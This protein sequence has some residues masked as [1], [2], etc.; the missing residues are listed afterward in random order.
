MEER[1]EQIGNVPQVLEERELI[2]EE[3]KEDSRSLSP[4]VELGI[5]LWMTGAV[6]KEEA[7]KRAGVGLST[8]I[9]NSL[10]P[11]GRKLISRIREELNNDFTSLYKQFTEVVKD[12]MEH[13]DSSIA[14]AGAALFSRHIK[15]HKIEVTLTAEDRVKSIFEGPDGV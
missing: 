11:L 2:R 7:A 10:S 15:E 13:S 5:R 4:A 12:A 6:T 8:L 9:H 1:E 3:E 14:L